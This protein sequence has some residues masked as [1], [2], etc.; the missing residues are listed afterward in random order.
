M[1]VKKMSSKQLMDVLDRAEGSIDNLRSDINEMKQE[2]DRRLNIF[3]N[4]M[5][6]SSASIGKIEE[7]LILKDNE[8][9]SAVILSDAEIVDGKYSKYGF[10]I[11]PK[12]S[13]NTINIFNL[14][15]AT[16]PVYKN[17]ANISVGDQTLVD[18]NGLLMHDAIKSKTAA[19]KE[20][21]E[22]DITLKISVNP[23][24]ILGSTEC[25][26]IELLP[27]IQGSFDIKAIRIFTMQDYRNK[28]DVPTIN[29]GATAKNIGAC[30]I[31]LPQTIDL[32][33]CEI[34]I[35]L[36]FRNS[37]DKYPLGFR[38][39]YFLKENYDETSYAIVKISKDA[40][41]DWISDDI[42]IHDQDGIRNTTCTQEGIQIYASYLNGIFGVEIEP[43]KG[44]IQNT[45]PRNIRDIFV[46]IPIK[47]SIT[48]IRFKQIGIR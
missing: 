22:Q 20:F 30:R 13:S 33:S 17:N 47:K 7:R 15:S 25:N 11:L 14:F 34:D 27:Y 40:Y 3:V 29:M 16:G 41:I 39:I 35:H 9:N 2:I 36:N 42:T 8:R 38:H 48:S 12:T 5:E 18:F 26:A 6:Y 23:E 21:T 45:I 44:T 24:D 4:A 32:Y 46:R 37:S 28:I 43:T 19:F 31:V 10:S 1:A